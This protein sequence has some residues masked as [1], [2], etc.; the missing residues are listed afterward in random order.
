M[1]DMKKVMFDDAL[2]LTQAVLEGRKTQTRREIKCPRTRY[3]IGAVGI[4]VHK[5]FTG[6]CEVVALDC[7]GRGIGTIAPTYKIGEVV[8]IAQPYKDIAPYKGHNG[9]S[10]HRDLAAGWNN[11]MFVK[12]Y[13]MPHYIRITGIRVEFLQDIS[14]EDCYAEGIIYHGTRTD[15][16]NFTFD[17][18]NFFATAKDAYQALI[19]KLDKKMW[20]RNPYVFVYVFELVD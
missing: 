13:R 15:G 8:A 6:L 17:N 11:K 5:S 16:L 2:G 7:E 20:E 4:G 3:G 14:V 9:Y 1:V 10:N 12:A 18:S 19:N